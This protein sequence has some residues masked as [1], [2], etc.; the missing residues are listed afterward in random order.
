MVKGLGLGV[1]G[2][3]LRLNVKV[4]GF[5]C[6]DQSSSWYKTCEALPTVGK[7]NVLSLEA[8]PGLFVK[9]TSVD[10]KPLFG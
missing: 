2:L 7:G 10:V 5:S 9:S 4:L 3:G 1:E 6:P 8:D